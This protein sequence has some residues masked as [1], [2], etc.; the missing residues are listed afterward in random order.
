MKT[1]EQLKGA[2]RNAAKDMNLH[3]QEVLQI[4]M[5]ERLIERLS[6]S[7]YRENF[8]LKGGL[9]IASMIGIGERTTMDMDTTVQGLPMEEGNMVRIIKEILAIDVEDGIAFEYVDTQPIREED[10]Y[11]NY[12]IIIRANYG[13][14]KVPMKIDITTGDEIT[15]RQIDYSYQFMFEDKRVLVKAYPLETIIAEKYETI[16]RRNIGNTRAR[17]FYDLYMLYNLKTDMIRWDILKQAII[18]TATKR[19]SL[20]DLKDYIEIIEEM[21]ESDYLVGIWNNY[22]SANTYTGKVNF[23][24]ALIAAKSIGD[25]IINSQKHL[26]M[27]D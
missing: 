16:I 11:S 25:G 14:M 4:F 24:D 17:D 21:K 2:I 23:N 8:I 3:A 9:L 19:N 15:P 1:S 18:A 27:P 6:V 5:F 26:L 7:A 12:C 13:K 10:E 22:Q 20:E